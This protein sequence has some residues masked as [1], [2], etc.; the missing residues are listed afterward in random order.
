MEESLLVKKKNKLLQ[1]IKKQTKTIVIILVCV[2][3]IAIGSSYALLRSSQ[4]GTHSYTITSGNLE[5]T[6][7]DQ[8]TDA[9][10]VTN[11]YPM[12]DA[13][14]LA[15]TDELTFVV[16]NTGTMPA[17]YNVYIEETSTNPAFKTVI[18][19]VD[20]KNSGE[21]SDIKVLYDNKYIDNGASLAVN[22]EA[23]YK[24]KL[25]LAEEADVTYMNK[26][27]SAKVVVETFQNSLGKLMHDIKNPQNASCQTYVEE[28]G[29]TYISGTKEC[30]NFNY[31]WWSGYMW[32]ITAIYPDGGIK[33]VTDN[34]ISSIS[35]GENV[36]YYNKDTEAKSYVF[37]WL[38]EDFLSTLYNNGSDVI[39]DSKFW[40][41][42]Q[43]VNTIISAIGLLNSYEYRKS[44]QNTTY[45]NGYL[46]IGYYWWLLNP[47]STSYMWGVSNYGDGLNRSSI[48]TLGARPT[49]YLKSD[50]KILS[51]SG[52]EL[53]PYI[54]S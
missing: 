30:I 43:T 22:A 2:L 35:F 48:V 37:Q 18:R 8:S 40:N 4:V 42:T 51:G 16:K 9:L 34:N 31:V 38:N 54:V 14:G 47:Y 24:V 5:V 19:Y 46:N 21:Y 1:I 49:Y 23:T 27:F 52:I 32:R 41:A 20:K 6:F 25:W 12:T 28:D 10:T 33:M 26:T 45:E 39:D 17:I 3:V 13:E 15:Q 7:V 11:M 36:T 44:Y 29:I 53:D 50:I